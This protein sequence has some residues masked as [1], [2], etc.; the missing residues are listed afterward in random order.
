MTLLRAH[1][2]RY[3]NL[4][5]I[6]TL[7]PVAD[8]HE[9]HRTT[10]LI[11]FPW[12][13]RF[14]LSL[15]YYRTFAAPRSAALLVQTGEVARQPARRAI[16]TGILMYELIDRGYDD[17]RGAEVLRKINGAHRRYPIHAEDY[18]YV[19]STFV[20]CPVRWINQAAWRRLSDVELEAAAT[21]YAEVGR[22]MGVPDP[23]PTYAGF[24]DVLDEYEARHFHYTENAGALMSASEPI[25]NEQ[26]PPP[27]RPLARNLTRAIFD[28]RLCRCLGLRPAG[29]ALGLSVRAL[30]QLRAAATRRSA[31][32]SNPWFIPGQPNPVYPDGYTLDEV[33]PHAGN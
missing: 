22:R 30:M 5:R 7:D 26:L 27:L 13:F 18:R 23:P 31:P 14:G 29:P 21:F 6:R 2:D 4:Q 12:D 20:V 28:R 1:P 8:A 25:V 3:R 33:G 11:E 16:D 19:L 24:E 15:A 17:E 10:A 32:P 9:I